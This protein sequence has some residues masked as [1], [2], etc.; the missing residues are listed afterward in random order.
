MITKNNYVTDI[1][2]EF[3]YNKRDNYTING[4]KLCKSY[5]DAYMS[6]EL[7]LETD[8]KIVYQIKGTINQYRKSQNIT[9]ENLKYNDFQLAL[10]ARDYTCK[11]K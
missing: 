10:E 9:S 6:C 8:T 2:I 5:L 7:I 3:T 1:V 11:F 4:D